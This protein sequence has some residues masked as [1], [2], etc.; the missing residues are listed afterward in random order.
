MYGAGAPNRRGQDSV[1]SAGNKAYYSNYIFQAGRQV[2]GGGHEHVFRDIVVI[3]LANKQ[4]Q[5]ACRVGRRVR[6]LDAK[7]RCV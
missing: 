3:V 6:N 5:L 2:R 1:E 7:L 4:V